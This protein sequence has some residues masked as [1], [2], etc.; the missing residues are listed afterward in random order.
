MFTKKDYQ[1]YFEAI[2]KIEEKMVGFCDKFCQMINDDTIQRSF[3][4][5]REEELMHQRL[6]EQLFK[7]LE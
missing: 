1:E 3:C 5:I 4:E 6:A 2:R 7:L